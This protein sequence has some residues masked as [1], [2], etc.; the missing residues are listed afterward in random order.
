MGYVRKLYRA[1]RYI[2]Y[3][4]SRIYSKFVTIIKFR[5]NNV[6]YHH[7]F[8]AYGIPVIDVGFSGTFIIGRRFNFNSGRYFNMMGRQQ[9]CFFIVA[10]NAVLTIGESV[11]ISA[12]AIICHKRIDIGNN[13]K[14]GTNVVIYDTDFHSLDT[15]R[16][17]SDPEDYSDVKCKPVMVHDGAF[18]G[19]HSTILK[20]VTIGRN[21]IIGAGSVVNRNVPDEQVWMGNPAV[22][23]RNNNSY[24]KTVNE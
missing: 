11:G 9:P 4:V 17:N 12:T 16:R 20:G 19:A 24:L 7:D 23:I 1:L 5:L 21:S 22:F 13:V 10:N 8:I 14:I 3:R 18:I 6:A 2:F 15:R